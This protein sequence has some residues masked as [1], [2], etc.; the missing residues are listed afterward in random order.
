MNA[1]QLAAEIDAMQRRITE[2]ETR[3]AQARRTVRELLAQRTAATV[4]THE[5]ATPASTLY[6][7]SIGDN[8][9]R[10]V[11]RDSPAPDKIAL[12][13]DL[14]AG[15]TDVYASRWT[16]SKTGKSGWSPVVRGGFYTDAVTTKDL[17]PVSDEVIATHLMGSRS[18]GDGLHAG[19]YP[20]LANDT[21]RLLV[22]DFDD[23]SWK[24][25]A[26]AYADA[27]SRHGVGSATEVS[28]SG[29][30]AHVWLFF[31]Q[32][33]SAQLARS[34]G[35]ALL[36]DAMAHQNGMS[37]TSYDRLFPSQDLLPTRSPGRM[38][39]GN[40]IALPLQGAC[41]RRGTTVFVDPKTWLPFED[42]FAFLSSIVRLSTDALETAAST[43]RPVRMG[44][45]DLSSGLR[46]RSL[47]STQRTNAQ[48]I[49]STAPVPTSVRIN[50]SSV[51][52]IPT[53][54][55]PSGLIAEL[56]HAASLANPEF[57][58]RQA[59]R[60]STFGTPRFV[61]C[62]EHDDTTL[63]LPRGLLDSVR[64]IMKSAGIKIEVVSDLTEAKPID[65]EFRGELTAP[66]IEAVA[67]MQRHD[68]GVLVAPPGSGKTVIACALIANL[69]VTTA[70]VV[71]R[72]ELVQQWR[73][74]LAEF[75]DIDTAQ[76]GQLGGGRRKRTHI[77]DI[78]MLQSIAH[79]AADPTVLS[80]YGLIVVDECHALGAAATEAA[81]RQI[82]VQRWIGL[83]ATPYRADQMDDI[84][85]MQCGPIRHTIDDSAPFAKELIV[86]ETVFETAESG[87]DDIQA[88][89]TELASDIDRNRLIADDVVNACKT[90]RNCLVLS[91]RVEHVEQLAELLR[92]E[93]AAVFVLHGQ[94]G[95]KERR[96]IRAE[97]DGRSAADPFILVAIDKI[98]GE[99]FDLPSLDTLFL[100]VPMAF[101]GRIVQQIGRISRATRKTAATGDPVASQV[102]D[103]W[104]AQVPVFDRMYRKRQR[105]LSKQGFVAHH[106]KPDPVIPA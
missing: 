16:S 10:P 33:V 34:L 30:G 32:A 24:A 72:A 85:T 100:A 77:I 99:G 58:R 43:L 40:L 3:L 89:Y 80:G 79:R 59:Q 14:F 54:G 88:I 26:A 102:H 7:A 68:T 78:V 2:L 4:V 41:R 39:L 95:I 50:L 73:D 23:G 105:I 13:R 84:I 60:F 70:I 45:V 22:C 35:L 90:G 29:D 21:C 15:R 56:K 18:G 76:I 9:Q 69:A 27:C 42:Q 19:L 66:Q 92:A 12:F 17:L 101:K 97:L 36:R 49:D 71:N 11:T 62:F 87:A 38:R 61:Y 46:K 83:T 28:R 44:P 82:A 6:R 106:D 53:L 20:M 74:R 91:T 67:T 1:D 5:L 98:A 65:V 96:R 25:D 81:V 94:L 63:R 37:L 47:S 57:Y 48:P 8:P 52:S 55:L 104:D 86:H 103:Y 64:Q 93:A 31:A 75:L 51:L